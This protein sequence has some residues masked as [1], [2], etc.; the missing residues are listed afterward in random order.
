MC[1]SCLR[2]YN[3]MTIITIISRYL[4]EADGLNVKN[5]FF[6]LLLSKIWQTYPLPL[7][8]LKIFKAYN[9]IPLSLN[10]HGLFLTFAWY[11]HSCHR[12]TKS[13]TS[14]FF[15]RQKHWL[16]HQYPSQSLPFYFFLELKFFL[17]WTVM[18]VVE[19]WIFAD[20]SLSCLRN[21]NI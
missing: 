20:Y 1:E 4:L 11:M 14:P 8:F 18:S 21:V 19:K 5:I 2:K 10:L 3:N 15:R 13:K 17:T 9:K 6:L 12:L 16:N 7:L